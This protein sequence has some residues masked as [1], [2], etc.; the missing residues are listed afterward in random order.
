MNYLSFGILTKVFEAHGEN[1]VDDGVGEASSDV[2]D[3]P[4]KVGR[5]A[6]AG[7]QQGGNA[8]LGLFRILDQTWPRKRTLFRVPLNPMNI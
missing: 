4:V 3:H 6:D 7:V 1:S 2:G 5:V 8:G